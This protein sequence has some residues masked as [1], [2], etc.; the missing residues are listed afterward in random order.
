[1]RHPFELVRLL[2]IVAITPFATSTQAKV[3]SLV[4]APDAASATNISL[5]TLTK[6]GLH[7]LSYVQKGSRFVFMADGVEGPRF[8][9]RAG[10]NPVISDDGNR[11]AYTAIVGTDA[12]MVVDG[13]EVGRA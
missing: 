8:D 10:Q 11:H 4:I 2:G 13:K 12:I 6:S 9:R 7:G 3:E 5:T 1:M